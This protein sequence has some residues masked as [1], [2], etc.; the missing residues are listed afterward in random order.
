MYGTAAGVGVRGAL[1]L[2]LASAVL[3][4]CVFLAACGR[5]MG[6]C[7]QVTSRWQA[8]TQATQQV[9]GR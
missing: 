4:E 6:R 3:L 1:A 2:A 9:R 8:Q 7:S 5:R